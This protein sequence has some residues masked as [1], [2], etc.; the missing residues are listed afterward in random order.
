M[1]RS[2][3]LLY[4][5]TMVPKDETL[6]AFGVNMA[7][8]NDRCR[9]AGLES[10]LTYDHIAIGEMLD[11]SGTV[12]G[13]LVTYNAWDLEALRETTETVEGKLS[14]LGLEGEVKLRYECVAC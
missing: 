1:G 13:S 3:D 9:E 14:K 10:W 8:F 4:V 12:H 11:R 7:G 6:E 5:G 2:I